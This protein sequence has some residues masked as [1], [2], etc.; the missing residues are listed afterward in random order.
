MSG[1]TLSKTLLTV[2]TGL[3]LTLAVLAQ[4]RSQLPLLVVVALVA[5]ALVAWL[6]KR[7][8]LKLTDILVFAVVFRLVLL[9]VPPSLSDDSYRYV[10][11]GVVQLSGVNPYEFAPEDLALSS[12]HD[13]PIYRRLNSAPYFT[14]YPPVSQGVFLLGALLYDQGWLYSHYT[15]KLILVLM[16]LLAVFILARMV[17]ARW[18]LIYALNPLVLV[19]TAGQAH[20][21]SALLLL[22]V[23]TVYWSKAGRGRLASGALALAGWVKLYPFVLFPFLWRR[24]R[25]NGIWPGAAIAALVAVPY[26]APYV[27]ANVSSS[28]DLYAR[29]FEFNGGFYYAIKKVFSIVTGEDWSKQIGPAL[30]LCFLAALPVIYFLDHR[31][32]WPLARAFLITIGL[33]F[34]LATTVHPW[35]LLSLLLLTAILTRASWHWYWLGLLAIGTYLLYTG[36]P[37]WTFVAAGWGGWL[38]LAAWRHGGGIFQGFMRFWAWRKYRLIKPYLPRLKQPL[39][40]LDLGA[41]EGYVGGWIRFKLEANVTLCDVLDYNR[42]DMELVTY[43]GRTLPWQDDTFDVVVLYFVV[44]HATDQRQLILE[45]LRVAKD[46]VIVVESVY[47]TERGRQTLRF[48]DTSANRFRSCGQMNEQEFVLRFRTSAGWRELFDGLGAEVLVQQGHG[49]WLHRQALYVLN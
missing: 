12:L 49:N 14:V 34:V 42:T 11:D 6:W 13:E 39:T 28:L 20:T 16:E 26:A 1:S 40:V 8:D 2:L 38:V 41:G 33:Y 46:R 5:G 24:F 3:V 29:F 19:E 21:E 4:D 35:Y 22:L 18:V 44:H 23:L 36:G 45:A 10:W 7:N 15:I 43:D 25:W 17:K 9:A 47:E 32:K 48:L 31:L 37:Y 27:M 30:R